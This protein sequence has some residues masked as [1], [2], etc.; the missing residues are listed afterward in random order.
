V[1]SKLLEHHLYHHGSVNDR[2]AI[3]RKSE[4]LFRILGVVPTQG[5]SISIYERSLG[6]KILAKGNR[7]V[8][9]RPGLMEIV[10]N[11][12]GPITYVSPPLKNLSIEK[13]DFVLETTISQPLRIRIDHISRMCLRRRAS[14]CQV[15]N[16]IELVKEIMINTSSHISLQYANHTAWL[17]IKSKAS[18]RRKKE[19]GKTSA[20]GHRRTPVTRYCS[21]D[22]LSKILRAASKV[23]SAH[24]S[25][26]DCVLFFETNGMIGFAPTSTKVGDHVCQFKDSDVVAIL[27]NFGQEIPEFKVMGRAVDFLA[28]ST[29]ST[30]PVKPFA[31]LGP[32]R[33]YGF[34][35]S[36]Y[37][38]IL[39]VN[40]ES[41]QTLTRS[42]T[43]RD[44]P[45]VEEY[46]NEK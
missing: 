29:G 39:A 36:F 33:N 46:A 23:V 12:R 10:G 26:N 16:A 41:F 14:N 40:V 7:F 30:A 25:E 37:P 2:I 27:R 38:I 17:K 31:C 43:Y 35:V 42:S 4:D 32:L 19:I 18:I 11:M 45:Q 34:D 22:L 5:G 28:S 24:P 8:R 13:Q 15:S 21:I 6:C 3:A 44:D 9:K 1:F 20:K